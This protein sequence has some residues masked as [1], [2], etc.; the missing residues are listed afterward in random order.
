MVLDIRSTLGLICLGHNCHIKVLYPTVIQCV[1]L[2]AKDTKQQQQ[3]HRATADC[4][5][6]SM[7]G[8]VVL[9]FLYTRKRHSL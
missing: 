1:E 5:W 9:L 7:Q 4:V 3:E 8:F 6:V 2:S